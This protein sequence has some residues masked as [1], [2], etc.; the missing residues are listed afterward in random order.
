MA[1]SMRRYVQTLLF[2]TL[3]ILLGSPLCGLAGLWQCGGH[4]ID[5]G[6]IRFQF[7]KLATVPAHVNTVFIGDSSLGNALDARLFTQLSGGTTINLALTGFKFGLTGNVNVLAET[8]RRTRPDTVVIMVTPE[9]AATP[10]A[11]MEDLPIKGFISTAERTPEL[12]FQ[13]SP[14]ISKMV[15]RNLAQI[16]YDKNAVGAGFRRLTGLPPSANALC[17][18]CDLLDYQAQGPPLDAR[19]FANGR[20]EHPQSIYRPF[21]HR[22]AEI[23]REHQTRC[24]YLHGTVLRPVLENSKAYMNELSAMIEEEGLP[25]VPALVPIFPDEMGDSPNHVGIPYKAEYTRRIWLA[26]SP[27][28][29]IRERQS[30]HP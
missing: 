12:L 25:V 10:I 7:H 28:L 9:V 16:A 27:H 22:M 30:L 24:I 17:G 23:C 15:L 21:I 11:T 29:S 13:I 3:L 26:L 4:E 5:C 8:L 18:H 6:L 2:A 14:E 20:W 19:A 1:S